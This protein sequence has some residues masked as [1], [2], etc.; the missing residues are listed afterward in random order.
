[1][2]Q[3]KEYLIFQISLHFCTSPISLT[4]EYFCY[5][6]QS[7]Y[8]LIT[9]FPSPKFPRVSPPCHPINTKLF[10]KKQK[11]NLTTKPRKHLSQKPHLTAT[12]QK[13]IKVL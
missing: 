9:L 2:L 13:P 4:L 8:N 10:P 5:I 3:S 1:M 7:K 11:P 12:K 6:F